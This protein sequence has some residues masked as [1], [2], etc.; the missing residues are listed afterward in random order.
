MDNSPKSYPKNALVTTYFGP[1]KSDFVFWC[2]SAQANPD[3]D[4][5]IFTDHREQGLAMA[6][7]AS[8]I[9]FFDLD[10]K[11]FLTR[12]EKALGFP[13]VLPNPYKLCDY[14]PAYGLIYAAELQGYDYWGDC[15]L[16]VIFGCLRHFLPS[17]IFGSYDRYF[18]QGHF[19]L[20][21]NREEV[22][23]RFLMPLASDLVTFQKLFRK[24]QKK[25]LSAQ[26]CYAS[27][28]EWG[29]D[30]IFMNPLWASHHFSQYDHP[31]DYLDVNEFHYRFKARDDARFGS[32]TLYFSWDQGLLRCHIA[33]KGGFSTEIM[34]AHFQKKR[35]EGSTPAQHCLIV[36][37]MVLDT[38]GLSEKDQC[39]LACRKRPFFLGQQLHRD[40]HHRLKNRKL[41]KK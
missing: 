20:Y 35:L 11:A 34:Y 32:A 22:N 6:E 15:D 28:A 26:D 16:D 1:F 23:R 3:F 2:R 9:R 31:N 12:A 13:C 29:F 37:N 39:R 38:L 33:K 25:V 14:K 19:C 8:N 7:G 18:T 27:P 30:E 24:P 21:A 40:L 17:E 5:L 36:P 10:S 41:S 4:F